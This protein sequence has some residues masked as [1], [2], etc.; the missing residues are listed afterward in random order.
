MYKSLTLRDTNIL[1]GIALILLL[2]HHLFYIDNGLY[3]D[4]TIAG[5]GVVQTI[6]LWSK[7]CVAIFVFLSG[8]GLTAQME[9]NSG[10]GNLARFYWRRF[11]KLMFNYWFIWLIFVPIGVF[12]FHYTFQ[13][14]YGNYAGIK[15]L[16]D[17]T[18]LINA[19]GLY[20]YNVTWW[21][22][23]CI[24]L[25]YIL[26]PF[27]FRL[28]KKDAMISVLVV[29]VATYLPIPIFVSA[30]P[31]FLSFLAGMIYSRMSNNNIYKGGGGGKKTH[32][33]FKHLFLDGGSRWVFRKSPF[34]I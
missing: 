13:D 16:L 18:G 3:D 17:A 24:I 31:Y 8:Y 14:A 23:S 11:T 32:N 25:L 21:F 10:V 2:I 30:R 26:F 22:Y 4:I 29:A 33:N 28:L 15:F 34:L 27:L 12:V 5:R 6:G 1:K 20:G 19:F 9:K 7:I